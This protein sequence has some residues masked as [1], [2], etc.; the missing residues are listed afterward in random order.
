LPITE[1]VDDFNLSDETLETLGDEISSPVYITKVK[2]IKGDKAQKKNYKEAKS[3]S[4]V[5]LPCSWRI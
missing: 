3:K 5:Q 4:S 1:D 2:E